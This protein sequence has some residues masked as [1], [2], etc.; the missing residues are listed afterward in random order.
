MSL[1]FGPQYM[2]KQFFQAM[3][4]Y[5]HLKM[6]TRGGRNHDP[7]DVDVTKDGLLAFGCSA[8]LHLR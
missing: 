5:Q 4:Q 3:R 2:Y 1:T 6:L 8:C 7:G